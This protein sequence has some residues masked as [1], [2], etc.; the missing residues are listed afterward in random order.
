MARCGP[1]L[2]LSLTVR[3]LADSQYIIVGHI[4]VDCLVQN[5][6]IATRV[7]IGH[8]QAGKQVAPLINV[9]GQI[10]HNHLRIP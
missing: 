6:D 3:K 7:L 10:I 5:A 8:Y 9:D 1:V 4:C 2:I